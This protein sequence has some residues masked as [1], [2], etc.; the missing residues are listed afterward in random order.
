MNCDYL[1]NQIDI[2]GALWQPFFDSKP[3]IN[4]KFLKSNNQQAKYIYIFSTED[5]ARYQIKLNDNTRFDIDLPI[6]Y[7]HNFQ[8]AHKFIISKKFLFD[9]PELFKDNKPNDEIIIKQKYLAALEAYDFKDNSLEYNLSHTHFKLSGSGDKT[10]DDYE[11]A[12]DYKVNPENY[13]KEMLEE[14]NCQDEFLIKSL[15]SIFFSK[16]FEAFF[17]SIA[18]HN[19]NELL[20]HYVNLWLFYVLLP[21]M[22]LEQIEFVV[23]IIANNLIKV[24]E[25]LDLTLN[26][27]NT[28]SA[29]IATLFYI[30]SQI[31]SLNDLDKEFLR[32][33]SYPILVPFLGRYLG[34]EHLSLIKELDIKSNE[35]SF[36]NSNFMLPKCNIIDIVSSVQDFDKFLNKNNIIGE[37]F[38]YNK[39]KILTNAVFIYKDFDKYILGTTPRVLSRELKNILFYLRANNNTMIIQRNK[40]YY[41]YKTHSA[42]GIEL[43][44]NGYYIFRNKVTGELKRGIV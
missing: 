37:S 36:I 25:N 35:F 41:G 7:W 28:M 30:K 29:Q 43:D 5:E 33:F 8:T 13:W 38:D 32:F 22:T 1:I 34:V 10:K 12:L 31:E 16:D 42:I 40:H 21:E 14:C 11:K 6:K 9:A 24:T 2:T 23:E 17:F 44:A 39:N 4:W 27:A 20:T 18:C 15:K 26:I 19:N 3:S